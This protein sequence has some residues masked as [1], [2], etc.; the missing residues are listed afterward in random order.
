MS[1]VATRFAEQQ[2]GLLRSR[3]LGCGV[4]DAQES[5]RAAGSSRPRNEVPTLAAEKA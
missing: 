2:V 4:A 3:V 1:I 5:E